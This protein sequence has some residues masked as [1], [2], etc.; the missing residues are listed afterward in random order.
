MNNLKIAICLSGIIKHWR[1]SYNSIQKWFPDADIFIHT[2]NIKPHEI[3]PTTAY[4][5]SKYT[6]IESNFDIANTVKA[7]TPKLFVIDNFSYASKL[8]FAQ[9]D[10]LIQR[11]ADVDS[12]I[13]LYSMTYSIREACRLK[14]A[15][16]V[17]NNFIYDIVIRMRFDTELP[18]WCHNTAYHSDAI[19]IPEGQDFAEKGIN[20][21]FSYGDNDWKNKHYNCYGVCVD[22]IM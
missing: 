18:L 5:Y 17:T 22:Y 13:S 11:G 16:E 8:F 21:Q 6:S 4:S 3:T 1:N 15:Y 2:W 7:Y 20:D 14:K 9:R 12:R 19:V 10:E